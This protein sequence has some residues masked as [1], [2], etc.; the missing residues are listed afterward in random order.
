ME[1]FCKP[2]ISRCILICD[3]Y[4]PDIIGLN[5]KVPFWGV[6]HRLHG[7]HRFTQV[8][9]GMPPNDHVDAPNEVAK[10]GTDKTYCQLTAIQPIKDCKI[11]YMEG[12]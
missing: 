12:M 6:Q 11:S 1:I 2:P 7:L 3:E 5:H 8:Y 4:V 10:K 9:M